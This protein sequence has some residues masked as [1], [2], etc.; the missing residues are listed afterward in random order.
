MYCMLYDMV[1][2]LY[3]MV[4]M[5]NCLYMCLCKLQ[6]LYINSLYNMIFQT[7]KGFQFHLVKFHFLDLVL[8]LVL[9]LYP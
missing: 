5:R 1:C 4:C 7:V 3:A 2:V 8:A 6:L 9:A